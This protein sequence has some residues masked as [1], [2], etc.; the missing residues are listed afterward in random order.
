[1]AILTFYPNSLFI[2]VIKY[3][4]VKL[5]YMYK[6]KVAMNSFAI[7]EK[8]MEFNDLAIELD[9]IGCHDD[10]LKHL[11][12]A[13]KLLKCF[14]TRDERISSLQWLQGVR[15]TPSQISSQNQIISLE[16]AISIKDLSMTTDHSSIIDE[17]IAMVLI[18]NTSLSHYCHGNTQLAEQLL[19]TSLNI[20]M[21]ETG[22]NVRYEICSCPSAARVMMMTTHLLGMIYVS[23]RR[24]IG[25]NEEERGSYVTLGINLLLFACGLGKRFLGS[26]HL[27][28][29][30]SLIS[31]GRV[32]YSEGFLDEAST[33]YEA[34]YTVFLKRFTPN[35]GMNKFQASNHA[36]AA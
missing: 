24:E 21:D 29:E 25:L 2:E 7:F 18:Y 30:N 5:K 34:A 12:H 19:K 28:I 3:F 1:M 14:Y 33:A 8:I 20:F 15:S 32:L 9:S 10:A 31:I 35:F 36:P 11:S 6:Q 26:D 22:S 17:V 13:I 23:R 27:L 16:Q 4:S